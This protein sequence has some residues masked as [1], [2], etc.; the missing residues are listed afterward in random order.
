MSFPL[1]LP[2]GGRVQSFVDAILAQPMLDLWIGQ[3]SDVTVSG[4]LVSQWR[5]QRGHTLNSAGAQRFAYVLDAFGV[6]KH[7]LSASGLQALVGALGILSGKT[8]VS[9][10]LGLKS[11]SQVGL[12][13]PLEYSNAYE[14]NAGSGTMWSTGAT[15]LQNRVDGAGGPG[16][17]DIWGPSG[18][19]PAQGNGVYTIIQ[20]LGNAG[21][22]CAQP[23]RVAGANID[24]QNLSGVAATAPFGNYS[25]NLG[26]R[27]GP[28][29]GATFTVGM[30]GISDGPLTPDQVL[31][32]EKNIAAYLN[33]TSATQI[34]PTLL[35]ADGGQSNDT[36]YSSPIT[37]VP[38]G[39]DRHGLA[40]QKY[41]AQS[42]TTVQGLGFIGP[43]YE[44]LSDGVSV[45]AGLG[46]QKFASNV[47]LD[48]RPA[49]R[50]LHVPCGEGST[51]VA[52][53]QV[54]QFYGDRF[55]NRNAY[56]I[57][58]TGCRRMALLWFQGEQ[59]ALTGIDAANW[60]AL[61]QAAW[62][63]YQVALGV[64]FERIVYVQLSTTPVAGFAFWNT[65]RAQQAMLQTATQIMVLSPPPPNAA[66]G[67]PHIGFPAQQ[68]LGETGYG[69][70]LIA[71]P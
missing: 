6:G 34:E 7:G 52:Q 58:R 21:S 64:T 9:Y 1:F 42:P 54:G 68:T 60:A 63:A 33:L 65:V 4:G 10:F 5:G 70:V 32:V 53:W 16:T 43:S 38:A 48:A 41:T 49:E 50:V 46:A 29:F 69:P 61:T 31:V 17:G 36:G 20:I 22:H 18:A 19:A 55:I 62:N 12:T 23:I 51:T 56:V 67:D 47:Y 11:F 13:I 71:M 44:S 25:I 27:N 15:G 59:E 30:F 26:A 37:S 3:D 28:L 39:H 66:G 14:S 45:N 2:N 35:L 57:E 24:G 40:I 8:G